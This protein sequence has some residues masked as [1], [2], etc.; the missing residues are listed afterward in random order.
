VG[1]CPRIKQT[2]Q[3][4]ARPTRVVILS[5]GPDES[6]ALD[7]PDEQAEL[8]F[9]LGRF[10]TAYR[11]AV[12]GEDLSAFKDYHIMRGEDGRPIKVPASYEGLKS[13]DV[14]AMSMGGNGDY[15]AF[16]ISRH[17]EKIGAVVKRIPPFV[18]KEKRGQTP[19]DGDA[20]LLASL[21]QG[22]QRLFTTV[23]VRERKITMVRERYRLREDTMKARIGCEQRRRQRF[24]GRIFCDETGLFPEGSIEMKFNADKASDDILKALEAEEHRA[25][26][27][28]KKAVEATDVWQL[29]EPIKG[30]GPA[31]AA[32]LI[33]AIQDV[34]RFSTAAKLKKFC[35]V[36]VQADGQFPRRRSKEVAN[37]HPDARQAL[38]LLGDQFFRRP[39]SEWGKR[40]RDIMEDLR[41]KHP[42]PVIVVKGDEH[43][44]DEIIPLVP[45]TFSRKGKKYVFTEG[46]YAGREVIGTM[47]YNDLHIRKTAI[48]KTLSHF[49]VWLFNEWWDL[50]RRA[51]KPEGESEGKTAAA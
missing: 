41:L 37:W 36:H 10:P 50:E 12:P 39:D 6:K 18:L 28:L 20:F 42:Y 31:I 33:T 34:R 49:V 19:K 4:E 17:G 35:G 13:G 14:V 9:V 21:I 22:E 44:P 32:R 27:E 46:E 15:F 51:A 45:G 5:S 7:L 11:K 2:A 26:L 8:D 48:W 25:D 16:A 1:I 47:K 30:I 29:F 24:V 43:G 38:Y 3:G 23:F 40:L